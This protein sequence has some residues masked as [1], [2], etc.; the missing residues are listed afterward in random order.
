M[1]GRSV[2]QTDGATTR[3]TNGEGK[4]S[5]SY[6]YMFSTCYKYSLFAIT[7]Y[8]FRK[9]VKHVAV[10]INDSITDSLNSKRVS[11]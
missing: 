10:A 6:M 7:C 1:I 4:K 2:L 11:F 3:A 8:A 9:G 5:S